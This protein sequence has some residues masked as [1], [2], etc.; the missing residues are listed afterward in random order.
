VLYSSICFGLVATSRGRV[1]VPPHIAHGY[2]TGYSMCVVVM[3]S[4]R[5]VN[6]PRGVLLT[7]MFSTL[8][9]MFFAR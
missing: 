8:H 6:M 2:M 3:Y 5:V 7:R 1:Q 4:R 9:S